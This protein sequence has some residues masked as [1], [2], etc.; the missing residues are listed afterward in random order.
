MN[1][2]IL[3]SELTY[4]K[5]VGP[6]RAHVLASEL[7][8]YTYEHLLNYFPFRYIDR[9]AF[10]NIAE[11]QINETAVQIRGKII[12]LETTGKGRALRLMAQLQDDTGV[13]EL[14][15]FRGINWLKSR[16]QIGKEYLVY[17]KPAKF[18]HRINITHPEIE[19]VE[20]GYNLSAK[21]QAVY[22]SSEKLTKLG[23][24][25]KGIGYII[26]SLLPQVS[27]LINENLNYSLISKY[28]LVSHKEAIISIHT[29]KN[30]DDIQKAQYRLKYEEFFFLQL[31]LLEQNLVRKERIKGIVF[32]KIGDKFNGFFKN[33]LP[34]ELTGAQKKVIKEIRK[35]FAAGYQMNRLLQGDVGSGKT[36]VGLMTMLIACDNGY[37]AALMAPTEILAQ[38]HYISISKFLEGIDISVEILTG[39]SKTKKRRQL[40]ADLESGSINILIGT[41]ALIEDKVIFH[42]LGYVVIDEQHRFGVQQRA[43]LWAKGRYIPHILVMTATPIPRTMAMTLYGDLDYS[44]IDELPPGRKPI[45]TFHYSD[46]KRI[47]LFGF[48]KK[49]I[50]LGRQVYIVYPL[51]EESETLDLKDLHDGYN[52]ISRDFPKPDYQIS[53]V[54]G[55]MK[56]KDKE[57]EMQRFKR[58]ETNIMVATT[59]IEVGVDVPNA[60]IMVIENAERF[61]LSQLHQLRG[62]VGRGGEQ[63]FCILMSSYK[64]SNEASTRLETMVRTNDGFEIAEAD[65]KLRGPGDMQ[66]TQQSGIL[67]LNIADIVKDESILKFARADALELLEKD[68]EIELPE[69]IWIKKYFKKSKE[70]KTNWSRIS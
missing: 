32:S 11:I 68:P 58:G 6:K 5:G 29:P 48:M 55:R 51:I 12:K 3:Q 63:S 70:K 17:G 62:R 57:E 15:W 40:H 21:L 22:N 44:V 2:S 25:G 45:Q 41:H 35:D 65:L 1:N 18:G 69:N 24:N 34:F 30:Y 53:V 7:G 67:D 46:A 49:Q 28:N 26:K 38:Q 59:V 37:Q 36:L 31:S 19:M 64:L 9:T 54:H 39:S 42:N 4:L 10:H 23:L 47:A 33:N 52:S 20:A 14:V 8:F 50:A 61:G 16:V 66:G 60:S 13:I 56:A 43:K 27:A